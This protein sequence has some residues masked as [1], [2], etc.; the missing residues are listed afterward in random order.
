MRLQQVG[1]IEDAPPS[2]YD[3]FKHPNTPNKKTLP[4]W[5]WELQN[6]LQCWAIGGNCGS[7]CQL[8]SIAGRGAFLGDSHVLAEHVP[9]SLPFL[10]KKRLFL[11]A[12]LLSFPW[13]VKKDKDLTRFFFLHFLFWSVG[14]VFFWGSSLAAFSFFFSIVVPALKLAKIGLPKRKSSFRK[15]SIFSG[16]L[17]VFRSVH[18][19]IH[20]T[21][22]GEPI[23]LPQNVVKSE[24]IPPTLRIQVCPEKGTNPTILLWGWD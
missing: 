24:G 21:T 14:A 18:K 6:S 10:G 8:C 11:G 7:L 17:L 13:A 4:V 5:Q 19:R 2:S 9:H 12:D 3:E 23:W 1:R 15:P 16:E 20:D 22:T